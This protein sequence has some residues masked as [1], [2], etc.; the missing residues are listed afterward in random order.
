[1][2]KII[3][4]EEIYQ[5]VIKVVSERGYAGATTKHM[6][7]AARVSEVTLFRKYE[8]KMQ[9][10]SLAVMSIIEQVGFFHAAQYTGN[11][12]SDLFRIVEAYQDVS[13]RYGHFMVI[14]LTEISRHSEMQDMIDTPFEI[15]NKIG[16]LL[17]RYQSENVLRKENPLHSLA[18][19]LGPVMFVNM[20]QSA[21]DNNQIPS[22]DLSLHVD[23]YLRGHG[24][25]M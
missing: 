2:P 8:S 23:N 10:V 15:F 6:A 5:A 21:L 11:L 7:E 4:D 19:L 3:S 18:A 25:A 22:L 9:L 17:T 16:E 24:C 13:A 14:L 1:M 20:M 12:E